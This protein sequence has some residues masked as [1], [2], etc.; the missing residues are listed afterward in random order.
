MI[1][2]YETEFQGLLALADAAMALAVV[3]GLSL[4]RFGTDWGA[5]WGGQLPQPLSFL[6]AYLAAWI[7]L[8]AVHGLYR[9]RVHWTLRREA[10]GVLQATAW[11][12][13]A[14]FGALFFLDL[15]DVSRAYLLTLF[16][17]LAL[18]TI[19]SRAVLRWGF[20]AVRRRGRNLRFVVIVGDDEA[21]RRF[22]SKLEAHPE[23][24]LRVEGVV[25]DTAGDMVGRWPRLGDLDD[26]QR[27]LESH[28][29]DEVVVCLP[30]EEWH[31]VRAI[32]TLCEEEGKIVRIPLELTNPATATGHMEDFD[33]VPVLSLVTGPDRA[34]E[35]F[36]KRAIDIVGS[37]VGLVLLSPIL[38][39]AALAIA[40]GDGRPVLF[41]QPRAGLHGRP[42]RIVKFRTMSRD[43]DSQ[44]A[45]LREFNEVRGS[46]SFKMT[47]DPRI[48]RVGRWLRRT[49]IDE[50]PQLWNVL[51]GEMSL[52]GPRPHP[53]DDV[54]GYDAWH[55][56]RLSMKPGITGLWQI[57]SRRDDDF[58]R[59]VRKDLEYID[60]WN[61]WLDLRVLIATVPA[62]LRA[63]GR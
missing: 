51:R 41:R 36:A 63:E 9:P 18:V 21:G 32:A 33:G 8:L 27:V 35:L 13:I 56:R 59:W 11:L 12:A 52:V 47:N 17:A 6:C 5:A 14:T 7:A 50:L 2:R 62:L 48:T 25:A 39:G 30:F 58:D 1:R 45:A 26:L 34:I 44:R 57:G 15:T 49:S 24:G 29:V 28:V 55:R 54:A 38:L 37:L 31:R 22:A 46:A 60:G 19:G 43:A 10:Q 42:F 16:P 20:H 61:L 3:V 40:L 53:F 23:L 4:A